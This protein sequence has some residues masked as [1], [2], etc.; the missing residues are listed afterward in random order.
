MKILTLEV[1]DKQIA[2]LEKIGASGLYGKTLGDVATCMMNQGIID[3]PFF[4]DKGEQKKG[5]S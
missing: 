1:T 5:E 2:A 3:N 4:R